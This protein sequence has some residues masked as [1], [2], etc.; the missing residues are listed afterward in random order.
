MMD[1][2]DLAQALKAVRSGRQ[3][4]CRCIVHEDSAPSMIIFDG[5]EQV[6]VR[7][8]AGCDQRDLIAELKRRGLWEH[9]QL[10]PV[11]RSTASE[12]AEKLRGTVSHETKMMEIAR[13]VFDGAV[14]TIGT[15]AQRY[16]ERRGI[17]TVAHDVEDIRYHP[18][19]P[20]EREKQPALV[21]A[22][23]RIHSRE[24]CAVQRIYLTHDA[25]KDGAMM[26]GPAGG[27]AMVLGSVVRTELHIAE[28]CESALSVMAMDH[29]PTWAMGSCGA[30][31]R[32]EVIEGIERL[33]IWADHDRLDARTGKRPG[34]AAADACAAR[35]RAAGRQVTVWVPDQEGDDPA[36]VW[37][38]RNARP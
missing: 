6:Q 17:W 11:L 38:A 18:E 35:W 4:K 36:D 19:C 24:V 37:R 8:L 26:L 12:R 20:R 29:G 13:R 32:F 28:G 34:V 2:A 21:I 14:L 31:D 10:D 3:W 27:C 1:A 23:R 25:R 9:R 30:I 15:L 33:T 7:C 22:M 16:L 5:R